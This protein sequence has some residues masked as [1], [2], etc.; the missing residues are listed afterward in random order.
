[1]TA[2]GVT[3]MKST[4]NENKWGWN[5]NTRLVAGLVAGAGFGFLVGKVFKHGHPGVKADGADVTALGLAAFYLVTT[6]LLLW[7]AS[8]RMRLARVLEGKGADIPASDDEVRS[9]VYQ[10]VVMA[11]AGILLALPIFGARLFADNL[12]HRAISFAGIVLLF[13]VQTFYN[14]RLW[15]VS[16][17]FVR[18]TMAKTAALTF[19]IGQGGLFLRAAAEHMSLVKP[20]S[21]WDLLVIMMQ[22]YIF[23]GLFISVRTLDKSRK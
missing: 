1:M 20:V 9:F 21:T 22:L 15:R 12:Q 16:D 11:L 3:I 13:A 2:E 6:L 5:T 17:E 14:V 23:V 10:A 4:G 18:S 7:I 8:N 19:A